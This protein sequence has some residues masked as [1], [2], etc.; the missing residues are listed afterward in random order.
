MMY[1]LSI[2]AP[3]S[4]AMAVIM[5]LTTFGKELWHKFKFYVL[6]YRFEGQRRI[7]KLYKTPM[8]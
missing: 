4:I 5:Y 3:V 1:F 6:R 2:F 7:T 8:I